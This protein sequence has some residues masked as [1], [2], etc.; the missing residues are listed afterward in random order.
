LKLLIVSDLH[1]EFHRDHGE[2]LVADLADA[3]IA[4]L[5]GD[6]GVLQGGSLKTI[7]TT[8]SKK[9]AN[10]VYT[11]GNHE[12][13]GSV[14]AVA[15][16]EIAAMCSQFG[17]IYLL[18]D[19]PV[20]ISGR[21]FI[22]GTLWFPEPEQYTKKFGRD[23]M[24]DFTTI[25]KFEPWVYERGRRDV[26]MIQ[27]NVM[28]TDVVVTHMIPHNDLVTERWQGSK[29]NAFFVGGIDDC[30]LVT[31]KLW[32]YGHT[33]DSTDKTLGL[34]RFVCNPFGYARQSENPKFNPKLL[35][36]V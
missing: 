4:V 16:A 34:T 14:A 18:R 35:I 31:P 9:Y 19:E 3:D 36:E 25:R 29:L 17:N 6:V 15:E 10:V 27:K 5:A 20:T 13:Y 11:L 26:D 12:F 7:L 33:H 2:S 24:A 22:G 32:V 30:T 1:A 21:R 28:E 8:F 23:S